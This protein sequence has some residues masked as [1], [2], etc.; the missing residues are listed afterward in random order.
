MEKNV[1]VIIS[2]EDY[3][4]FIGYEENIDKIDKAYDKFSKYIADLYKQGLLKNLNYLAE[5]YDK[6]SRNKKDMKI[7]QEAARIFKESAEFLCSNF[8]FEKGF[9]NLLKFIKDE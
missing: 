6:V 4:K 3:K 8:S 5:E 7:E 2:M 9:P 1:S